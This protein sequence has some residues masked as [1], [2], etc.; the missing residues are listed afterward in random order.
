MS[1]LRYLSP[2][3]GRESRDAGALSPRD[4]DSPSLKLHVTNWGV[5]ILPAIEEG[6]AN[7]DQPRDDHMLHGELEVRVAGPRRCRRI[8]V[9]LRSIIRLDMGQGRKLEEDVLFER[10]VEIIGAS[11]D[12]IWLAPG[13]QR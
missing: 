13:S 7:L 11:A 8:R 4:S 5:I 6:S 3:R 1:M 10:K 9:G 12:G 2:G